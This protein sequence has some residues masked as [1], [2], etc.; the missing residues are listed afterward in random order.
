M[1]L[2]VQLSELDGRKEALDAGSGVRVRHIRCSVIVA[3]DE[4]GLSCNVFG[5]VAYCDK[6]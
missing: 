3:F 4:S 6:V 5:P 2:I 1:V